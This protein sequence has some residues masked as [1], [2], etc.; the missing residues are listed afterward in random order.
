MLASIPVIQKRGRPRP[1]S[2]GL[3][4]VAVAIV[5][6]NAQKLD[7]SKLNHGK[8][9]EMTTRTGHAD[10]IQPRLSPACTFNHHRGIGNGGS[11]IEKIVLVHMRKAGG[12]SMKAYLG[13]VSTKYNITLQDFEGERPILPEHSDGKT[14]F[15]THIREPASRVLS[16]YKYEM[17]WYCKHLTDKKKTFDPVNS[18]RTTLDRFVERENKPNTAGGEKGNLWECSH[19]CYAK[20]STGLCWIEGAFDES[21][22]CWSRENGE[23]SLLSRAREVLYSYHLIV[24]IE[25]L[26]NPEY[27]KAIEALFGLEGIAK[28]RT[29]MWCGKESAA[30]NKKF[31]LVVPEETRQRILHF[32]QLDTILYNELTTCSRLD[33]PNRSIFV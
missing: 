20:W 27:V 16:H 29:D 5:A 8:N 17:R 11:R 30:A 25:W 13:E 10:E 9:I 21:T 18:S 14:L 33:F 1:S 19:N 23:G 26:Q 4:I 32:N 7:F 15:V 22:M 24:V 6:F 12:T 28:Q 3:I 2:V 31:P